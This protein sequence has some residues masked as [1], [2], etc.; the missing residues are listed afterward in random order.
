MA[1]LLE[2][3]TIDELE[4]MQQ[5][6]A[7]EIGIESYKRL[8][9]V[10]G[11][12]SIYICKADEIIKRARNIEIKERYNGYNLYHL[13]KE[14]NLTDRQIRNIVADVKISGAVEG[15]LSLFKNE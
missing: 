8:V 4:G 1:D 11:G 5:D 12:V 2:R 13:A 10:M 14:F 6:V 15:Q 7:R 3:L 9:R